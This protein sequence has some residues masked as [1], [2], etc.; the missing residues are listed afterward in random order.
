MVRN[1]IEAEAAVAPPMRMSFEDFLLHGPDGV[2]AEWVD[3]EVIILSNTTRHGRL[4]AMLFS[5]FRSFAAMLDLG[6]VFIPPF[7]MRA[8]PGGPGREPDVVVILKANRHRIKRIGMEGPADLVVE[9]LSEETARTD[10][11]A[12]R[13]EYAEA[14]VTEYLVVEGRDGRRG[15][16]FFQLGPGGDYGEVAPNE[17][18]H[19]ASTVLPGLWIDP[20]WF[21]RDP[22]PAPEAL[23]RRIAGNAYL[24][25]IAAADEGI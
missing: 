10:L 7:V 1:I 19:Y 15:F 9:V 3:G 8:S 24:E 16:T 2:H 12:K 25:W 23:L 21:E 17:L 22:L 14:G 11:I 20:A 13:Q 4:T 6:E 18:G 5:L